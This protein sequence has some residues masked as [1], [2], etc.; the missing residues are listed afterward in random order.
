V[1]NQKMLNK[2]KFIATFSVVYF[3]KNLNTGG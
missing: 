3:I 1:N 2:K